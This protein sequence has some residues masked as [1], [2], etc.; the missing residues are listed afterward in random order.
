MSVVPEAAVPSLSTMA[1]VPPLS[2]ACMQCSD[3]NEVEAIERAV[4][5]YPWTMR[6]FKDSLQSGYECWIVRD[7]SGTLHG[8]FLLMPAPDVMHLLNITVLPELHGRGLGRVLLDRIIMI[9]RSREAPALLLE[10]RPSNLHALAVYQH[11][12]FHQIG[13]RKNYYPASH[14]TREDAI[15]MQMTL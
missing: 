9:A 5:P 4:Y 3:L 10:V 11:V 8:Y 7:S 15:I 2:I 13:V 6:N 1:A 14:E 12:G